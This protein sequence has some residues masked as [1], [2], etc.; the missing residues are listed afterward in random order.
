M[1][2]SVQLNSGR[3]WMIAAVLAHLAVSIVHG[4]AHGEAHVPLSR[5]ANLFVLIVV[6]AGPL[7]GVALRW[8][9]APIGRWVIAITMAASLM[10]GLVNHF[11]LAGPDRVARVAGEGRLLFIAT[12]VLL[13]V[14]EALACGLAIRCAR[15]AIFPP[16]RPEC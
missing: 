2:T 6:V 11:V 16:V 1:S 9:A 14:T 3:G 10:F 5:P 13:A 7:A 12:A 4:A 15:G 8:L